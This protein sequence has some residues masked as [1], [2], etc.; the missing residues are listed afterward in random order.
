[1][2]KLL[3]L[4][5]FLAAASAYGDNALRWYSGLLEMPLLLQGGCGDPA[6]VGQAIAVYD[7]PSK[8]G[9]RIA[10]IRLQEHDPQ[11]PSCLG[12]FVV[13]A[14]AEKARGALPVSEYGYEERGAIVINERKEWWEIRLDRGTGWIRKRDAGDGVYDYDAIVIGAIAWMVPQWDGRTYAKPGVES[15]MT[16]WTRRNW[17][18]HVDVN[19]KRSQWID[20]R[21]WFEVEYLSESVCGGHPKVIG[22]GWVRGYTR[23]GLPT[24]DF[25]ARGC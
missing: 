1:M 25:P 20:G 10:T 6:K 2:R 15:T 21:L 22:T 16:R 4:S 11:F 24:I 12:M 23:D 13:P 19:V 17:Q 7:T 8:D 5:C 18:Q 9:K 3:V 14:G